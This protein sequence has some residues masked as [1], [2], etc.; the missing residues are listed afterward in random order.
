MPSAHALRIFLFASPRLEIEG[1]SFPLPQ[2]EVLLR[3]F[4]RLTLQADTAIPRKSLAFS[5]WP[6]ES[7]SDALANL[8]RHLYLL[9]NALPESLQESLIITTQTVSLQLPMGTWVDV[10]AFEKE[11][12]SL[13]EMKAAAELYVGDLAQELETDDF[14]FHRREELRARYLTLLKN[15]G[16]ASLEAEDY[17][18]AV[19]WTHKLI[20]QDSW[21][22]EAVRLYMTAESFLGNRAAALTTYKT[23]EDKLLREIGVQPVTE[24]IALYRD[25]LHNH[26]PR[27]TQRKKQV[28]WPPFVSRENELTLLSNALNA[29]QE[30]H[31]GFVFINGPAGV[32]KTALTREALHRSHNPKSVRLFWGNC[33]ITDTEHP[34][35]LWKQIFNAT[36]P[37][38]ARRTDISAEWL[39]HLLL[40]APDLHLLRRDLILP[41]RSDAVELRTAMWQG[42]YALAENQP[43]IIVIE[44]AHWM[45]IDS[46]NFLR[47]LA[48][49]ATANSPILFLITHRTQN[50]PLVLL[51][52]KRMLRRKRSAV[53][54][55]LQAFTAIE[56]RQFLEASL[57]LITFPAETATDV[58]QYAQGLPL[59]LR[60]AAQLL[61][62]QSRVQPST[63][64]MPS[65]RESFRLRLDK[66][67]PATREMIEA[68]AILGVSFSDNELRTVL[69]WSP[70]AYAAAL[71]VLQSENLLLETVSS[72][73]DEYSFPHHL[74][75]EIIL[76]EIPVIRA[77]TLQAQV[78]LALERVHVDETGFAAEIA[79]HYEQAGVSL[80]AARLWLKHAQESIDL[81]A[82]DAGLEAITR[83]ESLLGDTGLDTQEIRAQATL[84]RGVIALYQG[85]GESALSLMEQAVLQARPFPSLFSNALSM[86]AYALYTRDNNEA[87]YRSAS[88]AVDLSM[89]LNDIANTVRAL[90]IRAMSVLMLGRSSEAVNDLQQALSLLEKHQII[91]TA[92]TVQSLN[93]LGTALVFSQNYVQ[94]QEILNRTA[95]LAGQGGMRRIEAAALTMLGQIALN[96]G[97]Y[98]QSI[99]IYDRAIEVAGESYLPGMWGKFVGRGWTYAL[100]GN[101]IAA[102]ADFERGLT[103]ASRVE[104]QYG[105]LLTQIYLAYTALAAGEPAASLPA[106]EAEAVLLNLYPV[107]L[108]A[109]NVQAQL[110]R[111]LG[112]LERANEAHTR[113][114]TAAHNC[115]VPQFIQWSRLQG[116]YSQSVLSESSQGNEIDQE[117]LQ[118]LHQVAINSGEVPGR[119]LARLTEASRLFRI[120]RFAEALSVAQHALTLARSCPDQPLIG[121]SL[122][123][124][125][126]LH[127]K[128]G[129]QSQ[130][131]ACYAEVCSLAKSAFAPLRLGVR[132]TEDHSLRDT[133]IKS[134]L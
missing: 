130:A 47:E 86:Q 6:E 103:I 69:K 22:E 90:N 98:E 62:K 57:G 56:T 82:F 31:G 119:S 46:L 97:R 126:R 52:I 85:H 50:P 124:I 108:L 87:A 88:Q 96:C 114:L 121:E 65:L 123:L 44:D 68:A 7:E 23:L 2:R 1:K 72:T 5:L 16:Q 28:E 60:E 104:S 91:A 89:T 20:N 39:N 34:Y 81:A 45:D 24:T 40:L 36:A 33:Q 38:L 63:D 8:R 37:L 32:G 71:D 17:E 84:Q 77:T 59:L 29:I 111:L 3:L 134:L 109:C 80:P 41:T 73:Q 74:I 133:L 95:Q 14:L 110:W 129:E 42:L 48:E 118:A 53:D 51:E 78:A 128:L 101:L 93:H 67:D 75:H 49:K 18:S 92:Q 102:K 35:S 132:E 13:P 99:R 113:A 66:L 76:N 25:I 131:D 107:V 11:T 122:L 12:T 10:V 26:L 105:Q 117:E 43:L 112:D 58:F 19:R 100:S 83:A 125:A 15:L 9:R 120:E 21:D 30:G 64:K 54:I 106:L 127:T 70:E 4:V 79:G 55:S 61:R 27:H 116:L 115:N 94:A